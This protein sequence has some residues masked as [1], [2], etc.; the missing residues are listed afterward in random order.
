MVP[1]MT[2][3]DCQQLEHINREHGWTV[4]DIARFYG[5]SE[6]IVQMQLEQ[7]QHVASRCDGSGYRVGDAHPTFPQMPLIGKHA[8][9]PVSS[10]VTNQHS[11]STS[12]ASKNGKD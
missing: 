12:P 7:Q 2:Q 8:A 6:R 5:V 11:E 9:T 4:R 3:P 1:R 10:A